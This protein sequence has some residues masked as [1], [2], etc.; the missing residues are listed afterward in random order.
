MSILMSNEIINAVTNELKS[1]TSSVQIITAYCK[2]KSFNYLNGCIS[3]SVEDK[4][5]LVRFRLD[6]IIKGSTDFSILD[7]G[8]KAGWKVYVRFDLH[9]KTYIVDN[10]RGLVGSAN[11]TGSGLSIGKVGNMEMASLTDIEPQDLE[12]IEKLFE[13]AIYVDS[14]IYEKMKKQ[15]D[16]INM[17]KAANKE[18]FKWDNSITSLFNPHIETLFS[19]EL[20]EERELIDGNYLS[21]L[22]E[23]LSGDIEKIKESFRWS[24]SYLWL[25]SLLKK[26]G[27][28]MFFGE[29]TSELHNALV[30]DPKPYRRDVKIMLQNLLAII[31]ELEMEEV[32]IDQ[33]NYS[34]R[35]SLTQDYFHL[36]IK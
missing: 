21:F 13:D 5:L 22:D 34:Q 17:D 15:I 20:P 25:I 32:I 10:K 4:R 29:I 23:T 1:A 16:D 30:T 14:D 33:P 12:K 24:N 31:S 35:V 6:D 28:S 9:A 36:S 2:E 8:I 7:F 11:V 27:G 26:H 19:Y 18:T 3:S